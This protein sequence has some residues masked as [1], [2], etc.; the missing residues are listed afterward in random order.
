MVPEMGS[1]AGIDV[2]KHWTFLLLVGWIFL[3]RPAQGHNVAM[4]ARGAASIL[5]I[6]GWVVLH[7]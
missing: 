2:Y 3:S 6:F 1:V 5:A 4:A 7:E